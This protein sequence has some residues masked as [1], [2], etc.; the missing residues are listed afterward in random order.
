MTSQLRNSKI[1]F[2]SPTLLFVVFLVCNKG[3]ITFFFFFWNG[4]GTSFNHKIVPQRCDV[5]VSS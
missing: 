1:S 4:G 5:N 3:K 2:L